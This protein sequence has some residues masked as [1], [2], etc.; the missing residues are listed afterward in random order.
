MQPTAIRSTV[1]LP[2]ADMTADLRDPPPIAVPAHSAADAAAPPPGA[3]QTIV[4]RPP[5]PDGP[6]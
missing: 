3:L 6:R 2:G 4:G 1:G 5:R